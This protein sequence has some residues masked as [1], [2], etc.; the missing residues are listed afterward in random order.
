LQPPTGGTLRYAL[1]D[2]DG[3][4]RAVLG[5]RE[6]RRLARNGCPQ[7]P[8]GADCGCGLI[9]RPPDVDRYR[10]SDPQYAF[11]RTRDR[12]CRHPGCT[13]RAAR[14]DL[15]HVI[16]HAR[17]GATSCGNL[18]CLCRRHHRLKTLSPGWTTRLDPDGT[19]T[20]TTPTGTTRT[21]RP[22]GMVTAAAERAARAGP[23][24]PRPPTEP[25]PPPF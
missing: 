17:G 13:A 22:P 19:Y 2:P 23:A 15:D 6:L 24:P 12:G 11:I 18:C 7:H 3:A 20:V 10:P 9:D 25:D 1:T 4:L 21:S 14:A 8:P 5:D 16:P